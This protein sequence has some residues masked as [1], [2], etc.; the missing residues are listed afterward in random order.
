MNDEA[1]KFVLDLVTSLIKK[2]A[3]RLKKFGFIDE[4]TIE[5]AQKCMKY[6][7]CLGCFDTS[8]FIRITDGFLYGV[9]YDEYT[10][11]LCNNGKTDYIRRHNRLNDAVDKS[12]GRQIPCY[13]QNSNNSF[14][15]ILCLVKIYENKY[16]AVDEAM[17]EAERK[18]LELNHK[19][20]EI[21]DREY[22]LK[23]E[24]ARIRN[25]RNALNADK[26]P[27]WSSQKFDTIERQIQSVSVKV[28]IKNLVEDVMKCVAIAAGNL[29][30]IPSLVSG[31]DASL[32]L[33]WSNSQTTSYYSDIIQDE[34]GHQIY[35]RFDYKKIDE[36]RKV[37]VK[38]FRFFWE[39]KK[40]Y[41][42]VNYL[43]L[44]PLN[45]AAECKCVE[46]MNSDFDSIQKHY[47]KK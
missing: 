9:Y 5:K 23:L 4:K 27:K 28:D 13:E 44:K 40:E 18:E 16:E 31:L 14:S 43:V 36:D 1:K 25:E 39:D 26:I 8:R 41:L 29:A 47:S 34:K 37:D 32:N 6:I 12:T 10:C 22:K 45:E 19:L 17:K 2:D 20:I 30:A 35:V 38:V 42:C 46:M 33:C 11:S 24:E 21:K 15:P 7:K 3:E